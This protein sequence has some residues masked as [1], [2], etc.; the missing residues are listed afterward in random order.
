MT[1]VLPWVLLAILPAVWLVYRISSVGLRRV[2]ARQHRWSV[3]VRAIATTVVL[4]SIAQ[5]SIVRS[6][7]DRTVFFLLDRSDSISQPVRQLQQDLVNQA[8]EHSRQVDRIGVGVF[9]AGMEVD[10]ALTL[11]LENVSIGAV[12]EGSATDLAGALRS[13]ASLLPSEGSRRI[14]VMSDLV[15][16]SGE[17]RV[18]ARELAE[19]GVAVDIFALAGTRSADVLVESVRLPATS[20]QGD[21]ATARISVRS[22]QDGPAT[23]VVRTADG[24]RFDVGVDLIAGSQEIEVEIPVEEQGALTVSVSVNAA[25]DTRL[26]NNEAEGVSRVL[27]PAQVVIVE[28]VAGEADELVEGLAAG[29]LIVDRVGSIPTDGGLLA[30]DAVILVNVDKPDNDESE[31]LVAFVEDLGRGL[32]VIGGDQ[33]YGLGDYHLTPLEAVL[34]VSSN[35]DDLVRRQPVAE[36]LVIDTSGSMGQCHCGGDGSI[37]T[38]VNK[39]DISRAGATLAIDALAPTDSVGVLSFSSGYDWVIPLGVKPDNATVESALGGLFPTGDTEI[40]VALEEA[41]AQ[42][43]GVPDALRHIVLFTDGWDPNDANLVPIARR[44]ADA[45]VTLSV[46]GTGEGPGTTL[47]RMADVGGGRFYPGTDLGSVPEVFVE[48][49]LTVA[50]NLATEGTF[51]PTL[52]VR[53]DTTETISST[54]PLGGYVLTKSKATAMINLEIGQADPLLAT[55]RRGLGQV[56][57]WT[58]DATSRWANGWVGWE[59]YV[60]F[61]GTAV[62]EVLPAGRERPPEVFVEDG[63][64]KIVANAT[65]LGEAASASARIRQP[66]GSTIA[67]PMVRVAADTFVAEATAA[68]PGAYW[69]ATTVDDGDGGQVV[70]GSGAVSSYEEE[71]AFREPDPTLAADIAGITGGRLE[72]SIESMF[73][74]APALGRAE[75]PIWPTLAIIALLLF[76]TDV[77][78]RRLVLIEGDAEA[79]REGATSE[80]KREKKR[81]EEVEQQRSETDAKTTASESETLQRLMKRKR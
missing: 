52:R 41:L 37:D 50:R 28:G 39:T 36:V 79:W 48:E 27:G 71:F 42:L 3:L 59:G 55:W 5:P 31:R 80:R 64:V 26:E 61:W 6:V 2:P 33:S 76:L 30:Y 62:R 35:P 67:V 57:A 11:G 15:E 77:A 56:T 9:G 8:L 7:E 22:N 29:G 10:T 69:V 14:V 17:A 73:D 54:P 21:T 40:A 65:G 44:I 20:R 1:F 51:F 45:G 16:T 53:S 72:P 49:T 4:A 18:A 75:Q 81:V 47:E 38:G 60:T 78:L 66:D 46:L 19:Q 63:A 32:V 13:A 68:T 12:S 23:L 25:F 34:P 43:E 58:S 74:P 70:S 24:Q